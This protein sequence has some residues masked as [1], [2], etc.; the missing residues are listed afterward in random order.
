MGDGALHLEAGDHVCATYG[1]RDERDAILGAYLADAV[2]AGRRTQVLDRQQTATAYAD[3][4]I[5][6]PEGLVAEF[7]R[8]ADAA[9]ANGFA[10]LAVAVDATSMAE[11]A[12]ARAAFARVEHLADRSIRAAGTIT[13][14]CLYDARELDAEAIAGLA[15]L[16]RRTVPEDTPFHLCAVG[17]GAVRLDGEVDLA[18]RAAFE[19]GF[20]GVVA[21]SVAA[22]GAEGDL[23]V[24]VADLEFMDVW[25]LREL[26]RHGRARRRRVVLQGARPVVRRL[27]EVTGFDHVVVREAA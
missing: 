27:V 16:H 8:A 20:A 17:D 4:Y 13:G 9:V 14:V 3:R 18:S 2:A 6:D 23:V 1:S 25:S 12:P 5:T 19:L 26:E 15:A 10:G 7:I 22:S 24:D 21:A 11:T